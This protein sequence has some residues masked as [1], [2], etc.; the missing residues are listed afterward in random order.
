METILAIYVLLNTQ[1]KDCDWIIY[2]NWRLTKYSTY[3]NLCY[4][5]KLKVHADTKLI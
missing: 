2:Q 1:I 3:R 4:T 5:Q